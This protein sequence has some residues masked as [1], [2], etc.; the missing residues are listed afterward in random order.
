MAKIDYY[1]LGREYAN[2]PQDDYQF[3]D[4]PSMTYD[5]RVEFNRGFDDAIRESGL[6]AKLFVFSLVAIVVAAIV[7]LVR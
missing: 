3:D 7:S 2:R 5:Q 1:Q 4:A 6:A